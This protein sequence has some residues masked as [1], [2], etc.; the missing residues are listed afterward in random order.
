MNPSTCLLVCLVSLT[1]I[2]IFSQA[3]PRS[4]FCPI[5]QATSAD[6]VLFSIC[7]AERGMIVAPQPQLYFR[8]HKDGVVEYEQPAESNGRYLL[9][10]NTSILASREVNEFVEIVA[11]P[12]W[13]EARS[14]YPVLRQWDDSSLVT[15]LRLANRSIMLRNYTPDLFENRDHYPAPLNKLMKLAKQ[16]RDRAMGI[17]REVPNI[18][19]CELLIN[20]ERYLDQTVAIYANMEHHANVLAS[21][22]V[23]NDYESLN[24]PDCD[25]PNVGKARTS[26]NIRVG[27]EGEPAQIEALKMRA[28]ELRELDYGGRARVL[29]IGKLAEPVGN[30]MFKLRFDIT[31]IKSLERVILPFDGDLKLGWFYSDTFQG[32]EEW[33]LSAPLKLPLHHAAALD[34]RNANKFPILKSRGLRHIVFRCMSETVQ[35]ISPGRWNSTYDCEIFEAG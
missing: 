18:S 27:Y 12:K 29:V 19:Y 33:K 17:V 10:T 34:W 16:V 13:K 25:S 32:G 31:Q 20:R 4:A 23:V 7:T 9:A 2:A 1:P 15:T 28:K 5:E 35:M 24:D 3:L 26:E 6:D 8:V 22:K 14:E 11:D 21:G 30:T